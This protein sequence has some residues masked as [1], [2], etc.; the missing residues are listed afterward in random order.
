MY[1][2]PCPCTNSIVYMRIGIRGLV[3]RYGI[4][5]ETIDT[6]VIQI[7]LQFRN[8]T[9]QATPID[10]I[11]DI[12]TKPY[13]GGNSY[14]IAHIITCRTFLLSHFYG[15]RLLKTTLVVLLINVV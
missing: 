7:T 9:T 12:Y 14:G 3:K 13:K 10:K 15:F 4:K 6:F 5:I 11:G 1:T 8:V 2:S